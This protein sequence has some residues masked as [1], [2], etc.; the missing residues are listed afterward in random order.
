MRLRLSLSYQ[1]LGYRFCIHMS[2]V[3]RTFTQV[4]EVLY[5]KLKA[6]IVWPERDVLL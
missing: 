4:I 3:S 5:V 6:L 1:D 2:T